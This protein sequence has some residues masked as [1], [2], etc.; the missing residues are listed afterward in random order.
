MKYIILII[1][2]FYD[3]ISIKFNILIYSNIN[4]LLGTEDFCI[5]NLEIFKKIHFKIFKKIIHNKI[6]YIFA[7]SMM[8]ISMK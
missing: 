3:G 5:I 6:V 8:G 1:C 2:N 4:R 7:I